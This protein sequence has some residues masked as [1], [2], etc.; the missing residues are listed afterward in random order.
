M[1]I[2]RHCCGPIGAVTIVISLS[3]IPSVSSM[4]NPHQGEVNT[5]YWLSNNIN[6]PGIQKLQSALYSKTDNSRSLIQQNSSL[7]KIASAGLTLFSMDKNMAKFSQRGWR[8]SDDADDFFN[9]VHFYGQGY[10]FAITGPFLAYG[11]LYKNN[12]AT[13]VGRELVVALAAD[14]VATEAFKISFGRLRPYQSTS[15]TDFFKGGRSFFSGDVSA[16][17]AFA[18]VLAKNFPRQDLGFLGIHHKV[19][20][21][22]I[23]LY[24]LGGLV[25]CQRLYS[26]NHWSSDVFFGALAGYGAGSLITHIGNRTQHEGFTANPE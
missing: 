13:T 22:P 21:L 3:F 23:I 17:L 15:S 24:S 26:N 12:K 25:A 5:S 14:A 1:K 6:S 19:P 11:L 18:T 10:E 4:A 8:H 7:F 2:F 20:L 9:G 16:S